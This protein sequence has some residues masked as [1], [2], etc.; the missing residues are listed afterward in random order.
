MKTTDMLIIGFAVLFCW[1]GSLYAD[2]T[3]LLKNGRHIT[4]KE[5]REEDGTIKVYIP[6]G[7]I[8]I[9][10]GKIESIIR[11]VGEG[12][13]QGIILPDAK[14]SPSEAVGTRQEKEK[15]ATPG[16]LGEGE[17]E[18]K[19]EE[20]VGIKMVKTPEELRAERRAKEDEEY[21]KRVGEITGRIKVLRNRYSLATKGRFRPKPSL[22][23]TEEAIRARTANIMSRLRDEQNNTKVPKPVEW[24]ATIFKTREQSH[25]AARSGVRVPLPL[26]SA[27]EKE[28]SKLR[29]QMT[30][31]QKERERLIQEMRLK[32]FNTGSLFLE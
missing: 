29:A 11:V 26:Y 14:P 17:I 30:Q 13:G 19:K 22:L 15:V 27:K 24:S 8:S 18:K 2:Y 6:G 23:D 10:K 5:Y 21:Q 4:V 32:N 7:E 20:P 28:L 25:K 31:L 3:L 1:S 16:P 12:E 9:A